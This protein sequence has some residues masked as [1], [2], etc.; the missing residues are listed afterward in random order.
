MKV[1]LLTLFLVANLTGSAWARLGETTDQ[2][3]ARYGQPLSQVEQKAEGGNLPLVFLSFQKN[4]FEIDVTLSNGISVAESFR[5]LNG[6]TLTS[7]EIQTLL[8]NN[9]QGFGWE[10]PKVIEEQKKWA[11]DDGSVAALTGGRILNLTS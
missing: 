5:K 6:E 8:A 10:A 3:V 7:P 11:R 1:Q 2:A 9:S 4:G